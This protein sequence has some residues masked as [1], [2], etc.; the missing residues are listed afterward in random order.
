MTSRFHLEF[1]SSQLATYSRFSPKSCKNIIGMEKS[2]LP[3]KDMSKY[4][5]YWYYISVKISNLCRFKV[6]STNEIL[7]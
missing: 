5:N 1:P 4:T 3:M 2:F 6:F 7:N